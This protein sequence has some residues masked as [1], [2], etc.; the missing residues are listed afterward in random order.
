MRWPGLLG[1]IVVVGLPAAGLVGLAAVGP[2]ARAKGLAAAER[3]AEGLD[4]EL[5]VGR[6]ANEGLMGLR[7][8]DIRLGDPAAPLLTISSVKGALKWAEYR[9]GK[10]RPAHLA[11]K[12]L[13]VHVR[14]D[15]TVEGALKAFRDALPN[16]KKRRGVG[17]RRRMPRV[18]VREGR[19]I[20]HGGAVE[21]EDLNFDFNYTVRVYSGHMVLL[22]P[23]LGRC[24]FSGDFDSLVLSC[25]KA[26]QGNLPGGLKVVASQ[27]ELQR[28]PVPR[29]R[30]TD[31]QLRFPKGRKI[32]KVLGGSSLY[33]DV[34]V[35]L[36]DFSEGKLPARVVVHL[37]GGR[38]ISAEGAARFE[39]RKPISLDL[40]TRFDGLQ[41]PAVHP[42]IK[43][44]TAE[45]DATLSVDFVARSARF[46]GE[47]VLSSM[48]LAHA[49]VAP[50]PVGPFDLRLGGTLEIDVGSS[51]SKVR[52]EIKKGRVVLGEIPF[53]VTAQ[54][55]TRGEAPT[56]RLTAKTTKAISGEALSS[57]IPAGLLPHLAP[58][59][60]GGAVGFE[61]EFKVDMAHLKR[62]V[63]KAKVDTKRLVVEGMNPTINFDALRES[64]ETRFVMPDDTVLTRTVGP[65][66]ERWVA[67]E[68]MPP[69]LPLAVVSQEDGGF[70]RHSGI[71]MLHLRGSLIRNLERGRFARG[72]STLSMQLA[73]NLF[74]NRTKTLSRKLEEFV[75]TWK[76]EALFE[77]EELMAL[78][79]NVVEFG[80]DIFGIREAAL[81]YFERTPAQLTPTQIVFI[82]RLL[83]APRRYHGQLE[84]KKL[85]RRYAKSM[86]RLLNLLVKKGHLDAAVREGLDVNEIW[87]EP[88]PPEALL[89][90]DGLPLPI[91]EDTPLL[92]TD[93][94]ARVPAPP[95]LAPPG[96]SAPVDPDDTLFNEPLPPEHRSPSPFEDNEY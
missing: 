46:E 50:K 76:L 87:N 37:P 29:A 59:E 7:F 83:P 86:N 10:R 90:P 89:G 18:S 88:L 70:F 57:S 20:D 58:L 42:V 43:A 24:D 78:Y 6:V 64:F 1:L 54:I 47:L 26:F 13:T 28:R 68:D 96:P 49:K 25:E 75:L 19:L 94:F 65:L 63:L 91:D 66:T 33:A 48:V 12:G 41:L 3:V 27:V 8:E 60:F 69:L 53:D 45:G 85:T 52:L 14:G 16:R 36:N 2:M 4:L 79:L 73:R 44:G 38:R 81:A 84:K 67:L 17:P 15:G 80:P 40:E 39:G 30:I 5:R 72:G 95:P 11:V 77:K 56:A 74:L 22:E 31:L 23:P 82:T 34:T 62:M 61:G 35:D 32:A 21:I 93:P 71:S 51:P 92:P 55:D 9:A